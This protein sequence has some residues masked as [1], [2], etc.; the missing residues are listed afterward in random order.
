MLMG[1]K[2][3]KHGSEQRIIERLRGLPLQ[4]LD[5]VIQFIDF[6]VERRRSSVSAAASEDLERPILA[7]R[8]RG[9]GERLVERLLQSRQEDQSFNERK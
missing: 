6:L 8:G 2:L 9:K 5:E 3:N 1:Q 7:L 4:Q